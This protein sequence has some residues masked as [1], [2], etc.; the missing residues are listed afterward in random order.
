MKIE[1]LDMWQ[2]WDRR[3]TRY[4]VW[5]SLTERDHLEDPHVDGGILLKWM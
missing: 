3:K 1:W 4:F 5:K 2:A